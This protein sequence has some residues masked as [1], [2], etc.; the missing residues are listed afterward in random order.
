[1]KKGPG[2][3]PFFDILKLKMGSRFR[4]SLSHFLYIVLRSKMFNS[5]ASSLASLAD[6]SVRQQADRC[7]VI[8][9]LWVRIILILGKPLCVFK[10]I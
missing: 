2:M 10:F 9:L 3:N 7:Y 4:I 6:F 5:M 8:S 1:M